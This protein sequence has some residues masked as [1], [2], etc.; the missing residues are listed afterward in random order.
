M[1]PAIR[2]LSR[3]HGPGAGAAIRAGAAAS[4]VGIGL[5]RFAYTPLLPALVDAGWFAPGAAAYLGAANLAGYL[6]G[7]LLARPMAARAPAAHVL[8]AMMLLAAAAF[9]AC[10][11]PLSF[12]WF[13]AWRF[14]SGYAGGALMAL[15]APTI[16][17]HVPPA[18]RGLAGGAI[19]T[20]IGLGIAASGTLVPLLL[21]AGL[22]A[23]WCGLGTAALLLAAATWRGWPQQSV[24]A[25]SPAATGKRARP[26]LALAGLCAEYALNAAGL[27]PHM[28]F[29]VDFVARGLGRGVTAGAWYWVAYG[30]G[31]TAGPLLA[32]WVADRIGFAS[33]LRAAYVVQAACVGLL[34]IASGAAW[35]ALSSLVVG[36]LTPGIV[37]LVLGRVHE[38][39]PDPE[40]R[41]AAWG[42]ATTAFAVG[43]AGAAYAFSF[44]FARTGDYAL[45]FVVG[46][47]LPLAALALDL[48]AQLA[49]AR[50]SNRSVR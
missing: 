22:P 45:L 40:Q 39:L 9:F 19:F 36:A 49:P 42:W 14:A 47:A 48:L 37:P 29:L 7:A 17:P 18:R 35:I 34:A 26:G 38:L 16:L 6:A 33:A 27:V 20:G 50:P 12:A 2:G 31:A 15:A 30:T 32:G 13:F 21:R 10:A 4:L 43:Q 5:A 23:T 28:V 3:S 44:L 25:A 41:K 8:R 11:L 46:A 24:T 1:Q